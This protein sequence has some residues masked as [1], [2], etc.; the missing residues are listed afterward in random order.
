MYNE[1]MQSQQNKTMKSAALI[2]KRKF[3]FA[4]ETIPEIKNPDDVLIK[5]SYVSICADDILFFAQEKCGTSS[6]LVCHEFSGTIEALG[7]EARNIGF[8]IG[9]KVS[10]YPWLFCGKCPYCR[11]GREHL[12]INMKNSQSCAREYI[13]LKDRQ[14]HKLPKGV[15]LLSGSMT[16]L[17]ATSL[18]GLEKA[19]L[20]FGQ[21]VLILGGGGAG[22]TLLQLTA[23]HGAVNITV[24]ESMASKRS[25]AMQLG[26]SFVIDPSQ[27][28][29]F[30]RAMQI[31]KDMG[32][33]LIIDATGK[34][35]SALK[36]SIGMLARGGTLLV[37]SFHYM[38][39]P[40]PLDLS[41]LYFKECSVC[42]SFQA[43][44]MLPKACETLTRLKMEKIVGKIFPF[45]MIQEAFECAE[46]GS[47]PRVVIEFENG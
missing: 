14:I 45:S 46:H 32:Y 35:H 24:S 17:V 41:E 36:G 28:N 15:S 47:Y 37:F 1:S 23:M 3:R 27:E 11:S 30:M 20:S 9:D 16:E 39:A 13:V 29:L 19:R 31:T 22:L 8:S 26:A 12:C 40:I 4:D 25:L 2:G 43:P 7:S 42:T 34:S 33:D 44:Y 38:E 10:G 5:L 21:S 18:H 6:G